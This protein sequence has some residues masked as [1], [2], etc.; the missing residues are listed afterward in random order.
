[1]GS[2]FASPDRG[3]VERLLALTLRLEG[4]WLAIFWLIGL[5]LTRLFRWILPA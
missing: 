1:L 3:A 2:G 5:G 4:L